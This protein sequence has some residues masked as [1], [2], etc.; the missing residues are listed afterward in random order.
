MAT[1]RQRSVPSGVG[2]PW[3]CHAMGASCHGSIMPWEHAH[4]SLYPSVLYPVCSCF[5]AV[6]DAQIGMVPEM[7]RRQVRLRSYLIKLQSDVPSSPFLCSRN[8]ASSHHLLITKRSESYHS[9]HTPIDSPWSSMNSTVTLR[10]VPHFYSGLLPRA[11]PGQG[12]AG[13][14]ETSRSRGGAAAAFR[15]PQAKHPRG[16]DE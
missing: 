5:C 3:E 10:A 9:L 6:S 12:Q 8:F 4:T 14:A 13:Y 7:A 11:P 15:R 2:L 1:G 16:K